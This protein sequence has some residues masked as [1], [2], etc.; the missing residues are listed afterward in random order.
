MSSSP[1]TFD[2][3]MA[4]LDPVTRAALMKLNPFTK[5]LN[6]NLA[7]SRAIGEPVQLLGSS[8]AQPVPEIIVWD[9]GVTSDVSRT[10]AVS[11][12]A[13]VVGTPRL[14]TCALSSEATDDGFASDGQD[15]FADE[16]FSVRFLNNFNY[17]TSLINRMI[18]CSR[19]SIFCI[20]RGENAS[21]SQSEPQPT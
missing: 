15:D 10:R 16:D 3:M 12:E 4:R 19:T 11:L 20:C 2:E 13:T 7:D 14:T 5:K 9:D 6:P 18:G 17:H 21:R 1:K 8:R